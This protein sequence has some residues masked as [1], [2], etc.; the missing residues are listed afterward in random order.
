MKILWLNCVK[1]DSFSHTELIEI[2]PLLRE[3]GAETLV[4]VASTAARSRLPDFYVPLPM[5]FK[6]LMGYR[7]LMMALLPILFA[8]YRPDII[9]TDWM[10]ATLV[11]LMVLLR[12]LG[13]V[14]CK[15]VHDVRTVPVKHDACRYCCQY[16]CLTS[17]L[18]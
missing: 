18:W 16:R 12:S 15:F 7:L 17:D 10:S 4:L 5:P 3:K 1:D 11:R 14:D 6:K 8:K 13:F 9:L 2:P